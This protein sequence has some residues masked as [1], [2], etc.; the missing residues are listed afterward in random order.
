M[1][2]NRVSKFS[3]LVACCVMAA[4][5]GGGASVAAGQTTM[6]IEAKIPLGVVRGRIDHMAVDLER[7]RLFVAELGND[8]VGV[9]DIDA[10]KV[11]IRL[12]GLKE[13]QGVGYVPSTD[14]LYVANGGDGSVRVYRGPD[15][16]PD[17]TIPLGKD[18]D[19]VRWD[20]DRGQVLVGYGD[21]ALAV[22]DPKT[23]EKIADIPIGG[24]PESFRLQPGTGKIFANVPDTHSIAVVDRAA[25]KQVATWP[26]NARANFPMALDEVVGHVVVVFRRPAIIRAFRAGDGAVVTSARTCGDADDIFIDAKR[27]L[28]YVICGEGF[29]D[30]FDTSEAA[31]RRIARFPTVP[32][33]RTALFV[34][35]WDRLLVAVRARS[36]QPASIWVLRPSP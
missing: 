27:H 20:A 22:I 11:L 26:M 28:A 10:R 18:A 34:P 29:V 14:T 4:A 8:S 3:C 17:K 1:A 19:N 36:G 6:D 13:P 33:A 32:G 2:I 21:G 25:G 23:R 30:V 12:T 15:Y 31:Y 9:V 5:A 16:S 24:H 7:R 35:E